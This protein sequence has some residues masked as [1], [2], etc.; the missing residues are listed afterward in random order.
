MYGLFYECK[1]LTIEET[2]KKK[3]KKKEE[4]A[5]SGWL[6]IMIICTSEATCLSMDCCFSQL[7]L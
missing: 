1:F 7:A 4:R 3:K 6:G 2:N 5:K